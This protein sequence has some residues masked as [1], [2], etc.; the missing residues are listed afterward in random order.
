M[1]ERYMKDHKPR[2]EATGKGREEVAPLVA[3][4]QQILALLE[5]N[6]GYALNFYEIA[7]QFGIFKRPDREVLLNLLSELARQGKMLSERQDGETVFTALATLKIVEGVVD[8]ASNRRA[9][10]VV[11]TET[12]DIAVRPEDLFGALHGD[13][14]KVRFKPGYGSEKPE[15]K[16]VEVLSRARTQ[17]VGTL[18]ASGRKLYMQPEMKRMWDEIYILPEGAMGGTD[19]DK[20]VV[21]ITQ[22]P[23]A[24]GRGLA[25]QVREVLG[26]AGT[27]EAEM[28]GILSEF[29]LPTRF[30]AE[31]EAE[32][33]TV[34]G[35]I[36]EEEIRRRRDMRGTLTFTIDPI[37]AKDFD[38]ALSLK[39]LD[40]GHYEIG[41]HIAD[42][43]HY[44]Q[45][46]T[47][48]ELEARARATSVY[49]VDRVVP[50]LPERLSNELCSLRPDEDKLCFS[51][52]FE[53]DDKGKLHQE[54]FGRTAIHSSRRFAYEH[55]QEV[56]EG[57]EPGDGGLA[58]SEELHLLN[59]IAYALR[60]ERFKKGSISFETPELKFELDD[61]GKPIRVV[62]KVRK[63]AHKLI[64]DFMLLANKR[65]AEYVYNKV[66]GSKKL[67]MVYRVHEPP[68]DKKIEDLGN[69]AARFGLKLNW[70]AAG[71][72]KSLPNALNELTEAAE[73][74]PESGIVAQYAI[75]AMQ[76]ARYTLDPLGHFGLGFAHY[77][78]FTSPI[79][80]YPDMMAHRL[81]AHYLTSEEPA[82]AV[83]SLERLCKQSTDMEKRAADAERASI[84]YKQVE[85]M[86][87]RIG[88]EF[89]GVISG[90]TD[91]GLFVEIT[92]TACE[93]MVRL[94]DIT[95]DHYVY[96]ADKM[97][98]TGRR[99][100][101]R[102]Q[103]GDP[104]RIRVKD[105]NLL[106]RTLDLELAG[107]W[108]PKGNARMVVRDVSDGPLYAGRSTARTTSRS[109][110]RP[111]GRNDT[112][113]SGRPGAAPK[114]R[115]AGGSGGGRKKGR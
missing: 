33:Q 70:N 87:E 106:K 62:A 12:N 93:G 49:L 18:R 98:L 21:E 38:D 109:E 41:I 47:L 25:G 22:W 24:G 6:K 10:V 26:R 30:T 72:A 66:K 90:L 4:E 67:P 100:G 94:G 9:F 110:G 53:L 63:D 3:T 97:T 19:G 81:L 115:G 61:A 65:V 85:F 35:A 79:R 102:F 7:A 78:H 75:R 84:K 45:E 82:G 51:A 114:G 52:I 83:V 64:E 103:F 113:P 56:L 55:V 96:D 107:P 77:S 88:E 29:G 36:T 1:A 54:W 86:K 91:W 8:Y 43:T 39:Y 15:G 92:D 16:V 27:H 112:R 80:R 28:T 101:R 73:G 104:V 50:M 71:G 23:I 32:A 31:L 59:R 108:A 13:T 44:V 48:L 46:G 37:N 14:V 20:V 17:F 89:D 111:A 105:A 40:N 11:E 68:D 99:N 57:R 58:L 2:P 60:D 34:P 95:D 74:K 76:K 42:V 5:E 69:F